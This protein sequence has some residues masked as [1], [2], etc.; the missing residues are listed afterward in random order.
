M[1]I[2]CKSLFSLLL[3]TCHQASAQ[4]PVPTAT[5]PVTSASFGFSNLLRG[6]SPSGRIALNGANAGITEDF[7]DRQGVM[8]DFGYLRTS[9]VFGT[10][11]RND[12]LSYMAGPVWYLKRRPKLVVNVHVPVGGARV[13]GVFPLSGG[14]FAR[15]YV[16]HFA[17]AFGGG[18][19]HWLSPS[20]ALRVSA[21]AVHTSFYNS[22]V[23]IHGQY[24]LR[25]TASL[26][27]YF[28]KGR[29]KRR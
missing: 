9:N 8:L 13:R 3:C 5:A 23:R 29:G 17:W 28:G 27:Y 19:E 11:H 26:L 18:I 4:L 6:A 12:V 25:T 22:S 10:G 15:G 7:S 1:K 24:D 14:G 21:D 16:H 20:M 2:I